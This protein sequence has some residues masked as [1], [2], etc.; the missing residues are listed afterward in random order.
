MNNHLRNPSR[1]GIGMNHSVVAASG[2]EPP[3]RRTEAA[4]AWLTARKTGEKPSVRKDLAAKRA[5][6]SSCVVS[7]PDNLRKPPEGVR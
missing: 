1:T 4:R 5:K 7:V 2:A 3:R 6:V